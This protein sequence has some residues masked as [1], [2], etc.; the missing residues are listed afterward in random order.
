MGGAGGWGL[1]IARSGWGLKGGGRGR[2]E[3]VEVWDGIVFWWKAQPEA[4]RA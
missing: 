4:W 2:V 3:G 1:G